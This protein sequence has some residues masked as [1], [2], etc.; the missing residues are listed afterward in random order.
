MTTE[1]VLLRKMLDALT[2][3]ERRSLL[4]QIAAEEKLTIEQKICRLINEVGIPAH[5]LGYDYLQYAISLAYS[6]DEYVHS[7]TKQLYPAVAKKFGTTPNRVE[8]AIRHAIRMA[9]RNGD[10]SVHEKYFGSTTKDTD[11]KPTNG[12]FIATMADVLY[13][14]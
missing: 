6:D 3:E 9:W 5:V 1:R 8:R 4:K 11:Q 13:N 10:T 2:P 12:K 14:Q 7:I